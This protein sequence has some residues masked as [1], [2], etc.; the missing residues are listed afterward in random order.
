MPAGNEMTSQEHNE[1]AEINMKILNADVSHT[2]T[3]AL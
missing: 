2:V 3:T 1:K